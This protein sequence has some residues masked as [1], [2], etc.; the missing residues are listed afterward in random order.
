MFDPAIND[1]FAESI[2]GHSFARLRNSGRTRSFAAVFGAMRS[3]RKRGSKT[4]AHVEQGFAQPHPQARQLKP[5]NEELD[6]IRSAN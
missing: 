5:A 4:P 3:L 6:C 1:S 2:A